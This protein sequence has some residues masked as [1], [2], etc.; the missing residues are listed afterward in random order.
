MGRLRS[1]FVSL[2]S[3]EASHEWEEV[4]VTTRRVPEAHDNVT[5]RRVTPG[6]TQPGSL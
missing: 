2:G 3:H 5:R 4:G 1:A 6:H